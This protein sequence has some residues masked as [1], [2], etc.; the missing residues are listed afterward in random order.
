MERQTLDFA[1]ANCW[2]YL[3][4]MSI[5]YKHKFKIAAPEGD[6]RLRS[7]PR[8]VQQHK[9]CYVITL[10]YW[11]ARPF[12]LPTIYHCKCSAILMMMMVMMHHDDE[13]WC[14]IMK[15]NHVMHHGDES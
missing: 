7:S 8:I 1:I 11:I 3:R 13:A 2:Q 6:L 15:M 12:V 4:H 14:C 10:V 5:F 9:I